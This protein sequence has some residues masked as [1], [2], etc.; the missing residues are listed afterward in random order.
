MPSPYLTCL[1]IKISC[2]PETNSFFWGRDHLT[3]PATSNYSTILLILFDIT[4]ITCRILKL[5][6]CY[7]P[8]RPQFN[9]CRLRKALWAVSPN[10]S[11]LSLLWNWALVF[12]F[13]YWST[14]SR[15]GLSYFVKTLID[16]M[17]ML[18]TWLSSHRV[19]LIV[20]HFFTFFREERRVWEQRVY[21][22]SEVGSVEVKTEPDTG[23][24][25]CLE[26]P[27]KH[28]KLILVLFYIHGYDKLYHK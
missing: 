3:S 4:D 22:S 1:K 9:W 10:N 17:L 16:N 11:S 27:Q 5:F 19:V 23:L 14:W 26:A 21:T 2:C 24:L 18:V 28:G 20:N 13:V 8:Y 6:L 12:C 15:A 7:C 25:S